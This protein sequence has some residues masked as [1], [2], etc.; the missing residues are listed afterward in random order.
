VNGDLNHGNWERQPRSKRDCQMEKWGNGKLPKDLMK[1]VYVP[2][3]GV[4]ADR[5][6]FGDHGWG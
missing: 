4:K 3:M 6:L 2:Q 5:R 1:D